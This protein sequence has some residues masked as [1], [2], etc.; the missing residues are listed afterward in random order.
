MH[1]P[2]GFLVMQTGSVDMR[3]HGIVSC[4][5]LVTAELSGRRYQRPTWNHR[6]WKVGGSNQNQWLR[7]GQYERKLLFNFN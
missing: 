3:D 5:Y 6:I 7:N 4:Q 2:A 1:A